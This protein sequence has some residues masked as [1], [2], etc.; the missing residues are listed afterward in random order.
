MQ[1]YKRF[2]NRA[3]KVFAGTANDVFCNRGQWTITS[4]L[5]VVPLWVWMVMMYVPERIFETSIV[6]I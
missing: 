6:T 4:R 5:W 2:P 3:K 1:K